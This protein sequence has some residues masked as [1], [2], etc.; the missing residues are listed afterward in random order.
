MGKV[1]KYE[2]QAAECRQMAAKAN[3]PVHKKQL[4][5]MA[6]AWSMLARE[7]RKLLLKQANGYQFDPAKPASFGDIEIEAD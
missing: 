3:N 7:R 2:R 6:E 5:E 1:S 4:E